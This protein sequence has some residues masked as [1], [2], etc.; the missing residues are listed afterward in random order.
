MTAPKDTVIAIAGGPGPFELTMIR[1]LLQHRLSE[2]FREQS[3]GAAS[4]L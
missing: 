2:R 3:T 1:R 4:Q